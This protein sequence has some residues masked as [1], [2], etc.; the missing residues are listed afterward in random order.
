MNDRLITLVDNC[1]YGRALRAEHGLSI[2][3]EKDDHRI[4]FDTGASDLFI[5]NARLLHV[6]LRQVD[7]LILSHGHSDHTGG[8]HDF[9][10]YNTKAKVICKQGIF[11]RKFKGE[12]ENGMKNILDL[13]Y[14]RFEFV[15]DTEEVVPGLYVI[16]DLKITNEADTHFSCFQVLRDG[17]LLPDRFEDE[18]AV[19]MA[20][21]NDL[22]VLSA[23]SHRGITNILESVK[24]VFPDKQLK[25][26]VGGYHIHLAGTEKSDLIAEYFQHFPECRIGVCH[27]S[28]VDQFAH[29]Y[30]RLGDRVFYN[31]VGLISPF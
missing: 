20:K 15:K 1:V 9:L 18:L 11:N 29:L 26:V 3:I 12:R 31:H 19:V 6:D 8:L 23:C 10:K 25:L 27:C 16:P 5:Q 13:D 24:K 2:Y 17:Q 21:G 14:S 4:L 7:C 28:G 22:T 30:A